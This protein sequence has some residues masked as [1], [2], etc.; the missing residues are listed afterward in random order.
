M[1]LG[2]H[3][4][5]TCLARKKSFT[6]IVRWGPSQ[7]CR[8][9]RKQPWWLCKSGDPGRCETK[10][11]LS[12]RCHTNRSMTRQMLG[13]QPETFIL[14]GRFTDGS[15]FGVAMTPASVVVEHCQYVLFGPQLKIPLLKV[16]QPCNLVPL[17]LTSRYTISTCCLYLA[18]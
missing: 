10:G 2:G 1:E 13:A 11:S 18:I 5:D 7:L 15:M 9:Q 16:M 12:K 8:S 14:G 3:R 6:S 17:S 4:L